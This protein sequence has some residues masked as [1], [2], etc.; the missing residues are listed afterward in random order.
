MSILQKT[1][2]G[3]LCTALLSA[4]SAFPRSAASQGRERF[5]R[6]VYDEATFYTERDL[7][8]NYFKT[9]N[10]IGGIFSTGNVE[11]ISLEGKSN[12]VYRIKR[13]KNEWDLGGYYNRKSF[14]AN[15]PL[16]PPETIARYIYGTYRMD[17]FFEPKTTY[18]VG[19]GGYSDQVK[20]IPL[21]GRAFTG[22]A[23]YFVWTEKTAL[24]LSGGYEFVGERRDPPDPRRILHTLKTDLAFK[25]RISSGV[26][27]LL[28]LSSLKAVE[29]LDQWIVVGGIR[30]EIKL[31]KILSLFTGVAFRFDN[32]PTTDFR[33]LDTVSS[34]GLGVSFDSSKK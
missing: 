1:L 10:S 15:D 7:T 29:E 12:T 30:F 5:E 16:D 19:G 11:Q 13:F 27:F 25:Q 6:I 3:C 24:R 34:L 14:D 18:F 2:L 9:D 23:H 31:Y 8:A 17:Y 33:K 26:I 20:G 21:G 4:V 28:D 22:I 32:V